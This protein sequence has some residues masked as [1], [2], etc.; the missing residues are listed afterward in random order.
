VAEFSGQV[1]GYAGLWVIFDEGH[2]TRI[3]VDP[4]FRR[5]GIGKSLVIALMEIGRKRG[6]KS[7]TLEVRSSNI[8]ARNLYGGLG[9]EEVGLRRGYY[10]IEGEDAVIMWHNP[11]EYI[12]EGDFNERR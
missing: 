9:F 10:E 3:V 4:K 2:I 12:I 1:V 11:P 5:K 8:E 7:F 6:C